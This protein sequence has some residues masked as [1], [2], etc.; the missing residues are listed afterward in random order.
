MDI[1]RFISSG[2][3]VAGGALEARIA[4]LRTRLDTIGVRELLANYNFNRPEDMLRWIYRQSRGP[5]DPTNA[6]T[7]LRMYLP[8]MLSPR[9][10]SRRGRPR[11]LIPYLD[12]HI[13]SIDVRRA[14][15]GNAHEH[16]PSEYFTTLNPPLATHQYTSP[17]SAMVIKSHNDGRGAR[18]YQLPRLRSLC[19]CRSN[20]SYRRVP[21]FSDEYHATTSD[22]PILDITECRT[23]LE[24]GTE[25]HAQS[26]DPFGEDHRGLKGHLWSQLEEV[27]KTYEAELGIG[28][29]EFLPFLLECLKIMWLLYPGPAFGEDRPDD[30]RLSDDAADHLRW[31]CMSFVI[32]HVDK[33]PG[34]FAI[35]CHWLTC[36][37]WWRFLNRRPTRCLCRAVRCN[38][39]SPQR[40]RRG[41]SSCRLC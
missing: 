12:Q 30:D 8:A 16:L 1:C 15:S 9:R 4:R 26:Y 14:V 5:S 31:F 10:L 32:I 13:D 20:P 6:T 2:I 25:C 29:R 33:F 41:H 21:T 11:L 3:E 28:R 22:L 27:C 39:D 7:A 40:L 18:R 38:R 23:L 24:H 37:R 35:V 17:I 19:S 34:R 36:T